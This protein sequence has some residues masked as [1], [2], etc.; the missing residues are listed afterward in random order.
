MGKIICTNCGEKIEE[1]MAICPKCGRVTC[2]NIDFKHCCSTPVI[3]EYKLEHDP[4][5]ISLTDELMENIERLLWYMP[6]MDSAQSIKNEFVEDKL[7]DECTFDFILKTMGMTENDILW[8]PSEF[9]ME[10]VGWESGET[11]INCQKAIMQKNKNQS[12]TMNLLRHIRN[13]IAH[14]MFTTSDELLITY[15]RKNK[16]SENY[17]SLIK[18]RPEKLINATRVITSPWFNEIVMAYVFEK[19]GYSVQYNHKNMYYDLLIEKRKN[20]YGID[21]KICKGRYIHPKYIKRTI[22]SMERIEDDIKPV[23]IIDTS[24]LTIESK[25]LLEQQ[26][27]LLLDRRRMSDMLEG[28]DI[29]E[30]MDL[31][32]KRSI[33]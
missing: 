18:I 21:I 3:K 13:A 4:Q 22:R 5:P 6:N 25:E 8:F 27:I 32:Y 33:L 9:S 20:K 1:R 17:M 26:R 14:G 23:L 29:L 19:L 2:A 24:V 16:A 30:E 11:C 10:D 31:N 7:Y 15:D 12:K 28:K